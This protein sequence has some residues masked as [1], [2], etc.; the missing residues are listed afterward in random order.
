MNEMVPSDFLAN[1]VYYLKQITAESRPSL[2]TIR[3]YKSVIQS[4]LAW[5]KLNR[6]PVL[7]AQPMDIINWRSE[8]VN[9]NY[10]KASIAQRITVLRR[11]YQCAVELHLIQSN[12][13]STIR[14]SRAYIV[15]QEDNIHYLTL[16]QM[17][18]LLQKASPLENAGRDRA[19]ICLMMLQGL[20]TVEVHRA[21]VEHLNPLTGTLRVL[22]KSH[23][24]IVYLRRD[25]QELLEQ[26]LT[27]REPAIADEAGTPLFTA[28]G[29][30]AGGQR[31]SRRGI[32]QT[33]DFYLTQAGVKKEKL[34]CHGLRHSFGT[35]TYS[36]T[37]D[38]RLTQEELRHRSPEQTA[39]YAHVVNRS[40]RR[41]AE[42]I[43]IKI[44]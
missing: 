11:F 14:A 33:I 27:Q 9:S 39:K 23:G 16:G 5:C 19:M 30:R 22:G 2:D 17:E 10:S 31:I 3:T 8:L 35:Q 4:W 7:S 29:N 25:V 36:A 12:P 26:Y 15:E 20:R 37:K 13:L 44:L 18:L 28:V 32:R 1:Y 38:L 43:P 40:A 34:S 21:C 6:L 24:G 41:A 42:E